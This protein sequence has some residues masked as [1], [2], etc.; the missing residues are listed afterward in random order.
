MIGNSMYNTEMPNYPLPYGQDN[1]DMSN[2]NNWGHFSQIVWRDTREVGCATQ[3]C[4]D[5][6]ANTGSGISPYF[7]VCNYNPAGMT[8]FPLNLAN[9]VLIRRSGNIQGAYSQVGA[10]LGQPITEILPN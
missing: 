8:P 9:G 5:G 1:V 7:T 4:P 3:Y 10:P 6:L 2:F